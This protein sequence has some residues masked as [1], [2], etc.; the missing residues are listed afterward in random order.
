MI[1]QGYREM[2]KF[3]PALSMKGEPALFDD[4]L[5]SAQD[6]LVTFIIG[7]DLE[8]RVER[9]EPEDSRLLTRCQRI[10]SIQAF[11]ASVPEMDLVLTD[12]G[13]GV[14]SNQDVAPASRERVQAMKAS[15]Q[16]RLDDE[17]DR[18]VEY[19]LAS[20]KYADWRGTDE[21]ARLSRG[22]IMTLRQF[23]DVA[24][25]NSRT[26]QTRPE[27]WDDFI[28][29][30]PAMNVALLSDVAS[31][32]SVDY[33]EELLEKVRDLEPLLPNEKKALRMIEAAV[34]AIAMEDRETGRE[35]A[36]RASAFMNAHPDDFPTF[37]DS[38]V[39][40]ADLTLTH[41][42]SPIFHMF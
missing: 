20:G 12:A 23:R 14:V 7:T 31:Y 1:V 29:L 39:A 27:T 30:I 11:L 8:E 16:E 5:V 26:V 40:R 36:I 19:L 38:S 28:R 35:M 9:R 41:D 24:V 21:F 15:L 13:F 25:M 3:L 4:A 6:D 10:I 32:V 2:K 34:A 42:D 22:L 18:L 17:K 33:A 37:M